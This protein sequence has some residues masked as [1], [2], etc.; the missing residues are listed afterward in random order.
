VLAAFGAQVFAPFAACAALTPDA[1]LRDLCT[2]SGKTLPPR[3]APDGLPVQRADRHG[4]DH[5]THCSGG[6]AA[7]AIAARRIRSRFAAH[8]AHSNVVA[9]R[10]VATFAG[11]AYHRLIRPA[12]PADQ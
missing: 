3:G 10:S 6:S 9:F 11:T 7:A 8:R 1:S 4:S 5:C 2:A 12:P